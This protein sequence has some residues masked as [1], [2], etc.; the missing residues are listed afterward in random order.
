MT[1]ISGYW[2]EKYSIPHIY[3]YTLIELRRCVLFTESRVYVQ[4]TYLQYMTT[5]GED[6]PFYF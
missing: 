4:L 6:F 2:D 5:F 1:K 3:K